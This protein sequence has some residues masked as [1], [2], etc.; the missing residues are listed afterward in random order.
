MITWTFEDMQRSIDEI[1]S[2]EKLVPIE[3]ELNT[4]MYIV[5]RH[6]SRKVVRM[7]DIYVDKTIRR[8]KSDKFM[9]EA[10]M[11][12]FMRE[13]GIWTEADD[14]K[15]ESIQKLINLRK[16]K[17]KDPEIDEAQKPYIQEA[18]VKLEQ[19]L[20]I[21]ELKRERMLSNSAE[22]V[23][24]QEKYDYLTWAS[25]Y[26]PET[27]LRVWDTYTNYLTYCK[28]ID[29]E[30]KGKLLNEFLK[31][32]VGHSTEEIR[33]IARNNIWRIDYMVAQAGGMHLL[34]T[35]PLNLT[36][37]QKNLI[38]WT[39][40]YQSI[41]EMLPDDQP[42]DYIIEDDESLD[43][44]MADLQKERSQERAS[45]RAEKKYGPAAKMAER[46]IMRSHPDYLQYEYDLV[47][48]HAQKGRSDISLKDDPQ[49]AGQHY[50]KSKAI[51]KSK[52]YTP[53]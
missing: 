6:P 2:G 25:S 42:E 17:I 40:Y 21:A 45:R 16:S 43:S 50:K 26:D 36:P 3:T 11:D 48:P 7:A 24:R 51:Q 5:F 19:E 35:S 12:S 18:V 29:V 14:L 31:F 4:P 32:L 41:Y 46:L 22:R 8:A 10:Q 52:K 1:C 37:D 23:A 49:M 20:F 13:K 47:N 33:Y 27:E 38:W 30:I 34:P 53:E 28:D 15:V 44:Y 39:K 9:T